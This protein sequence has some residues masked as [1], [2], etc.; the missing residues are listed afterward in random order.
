M[1]AKGAGINLN[2]DDSCILHELLLIQHAVYCKMHM[3][4]DH[5][6]YLTAARTEG[7]DGFA[8]V[9]DVE[10]PSRSVSLSG[11]GRN[12]D[13]RNSLHKSAGVARADGGERP[14]SL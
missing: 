5:S 11:L 2:E 12:L 6:D 9:A 14:D 1:V 13:V 7:V 4:E 10:L 3:V 8:A